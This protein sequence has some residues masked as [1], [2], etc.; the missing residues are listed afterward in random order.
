[1]G[2]A[3]QRGT[4]EQRV[5]QAKKRIEDIKPDVLICN[6]CEVEIREI[7]VMDTRGMRGIDAAF[8]GIC[9]ACHKPTYALR[10]DA[11]AIADFGEAVSAEMG[12]E[13]ML[14]AKTATGRL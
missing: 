4:A 10:G 7:G 12:G 13:P 2:Q 1:M 5:Q 9:P 8:A 6:E 14:G 3:K 11:D